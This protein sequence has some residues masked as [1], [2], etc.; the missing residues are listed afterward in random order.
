MMADRYE[1]ER[2]ALREIMRQ[3]SYLRRGSLARNVIEAAASWALQTIGPAQDGTETEPCQHCWHSI[4]CYCS[5]AVQP[6]TET[7]DDA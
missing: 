3:S 7:S 1:K 4:C 2:A 5:G 6:T